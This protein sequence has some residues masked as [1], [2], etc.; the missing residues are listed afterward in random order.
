VKKIK[1]S[2]ISWHCPFNTPRSAQNCILASLGRRFPTLM[3]VGEEGE[4]DLS[5]AS[6]SFSSIIFFLTVYRMEDFII[7]GLL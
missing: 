2:V 6:S 4:Q 1:K 3:V 7:Q 5:Q